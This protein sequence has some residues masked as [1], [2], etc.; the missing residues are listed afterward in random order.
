MYRVIEEYPLTGLIL[1]CSLIMALSVYLPFAIVRLWECRTLPQG[2][3]RDRLERFCK[4]AG[5]EYADIVL[6][7]LFA[8]R[9]ITAGVIGF[10]SRLRYI[11]ISPS[12]I[13]MLN[14]QELE[15]VVAHEIGHVQHRHMLYY[16]F[17]IM[18]FGLC[19]YEIL[20][21]LSYKLLSIDAV[22]TLLASGTAL[23]GSVVSITMTVLPLLSFVL[24]YHFFFGY[25][26]RTFE[27][28]AD[29]HAL[30]M[31]RTASGIIQSLEKI[32]RA[33][34]VQKNAPNWHHYSIAERIDFLERCDRDPSLIHRHDRNVSRLLTVYMVLLV[35]ATSLVYYYGEAPLKQAR[36]DF[37]QTVLEKQVAANP[38]NE[39][40]VFSL[41][42][43]YYE[44]GDLNN[45]ELYF[46]KAIA[47]NPSNPEILNNLAWLYATS[48][49]KMLYR[50]KEAL[51]LSRRAAE[52]S[53]RPHILDTLGESYYIN[54][55]YA[56]AVKALE[57]AIAARP[58]NLEYYEKQYRRFKKSLDED[59]KS[60]KGFDKD[61][62]DPG[63]QA[64]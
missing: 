47:I 43:M 62:L 21:L 24:Y 35:A 10:T 45:A 28:Q 20:E 34:S 58:E 44:E 22:A 3:L 40:Y 16:I 33:G 37:M 7:N 17:I 15:A 1:T 39:L 25:C 42:N 63:A 50:P 53:P 8:G 56:E 51:E 49:E 12:L 31:T 23:A 48:K 30:K 41:G 55:R 26:S 13:E 46:R 36:M 54:G 14:E 5:F 32:A 57:L 4:N 61:Q 52:L 59:K 19:A 64:I 27:R 6:W 11:L 18:G 38:G 29:V 60:E 2:P 9:L